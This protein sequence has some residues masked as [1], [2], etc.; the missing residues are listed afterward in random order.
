MKHYSFEYDNKGQVVLWMLE[1]VCTT[2]VVSILFSAISFF[3]VNLFN[4]KLSIIVALIIL[5]LLNIGINAYSIFKLKGVFIFDD[6]IEII[7]YHFI[8]KIIYIGDIYNIELC[9]KYPYRLYISSYAFDPSV[10][11]RRNCIVVRTAKTTMCLKTNNQ[12]E[13][14]ESL[15]R[16]RR[17]DN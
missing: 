15:Q 11:G 9:E 3:I 10:G 13:L 16:F 6:H 12:D 2:F 4:S 8:K 14:L 1:S 5:V 17:N 7:S